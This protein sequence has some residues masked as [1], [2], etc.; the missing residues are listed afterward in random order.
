MA[1]PFIFQFAT[2]PLPLAQLDVNFATPI[3]LGVTPVTLGDTFLTLDGLTSVTSTD[4][5]GNLT[6]NADTVTDGVYTVGDQTIDGTKTFS[7]LIGGSIDG[8]AGTV[9]DG[10]YTTGI[11]FDPAWITALSGEKIIGA[12]N[13]VSI[14]L[15]TP[16]GG[17]FTYAHTSSI[18][19]VQGGSSITVDCALSNVF[20]T[21]LSASITSVTFTNPHDGQT[22]NWFITQDAT[23][24]RTMGW[25]GSF[26]FPG[27]VANGALS[28]AANAVDLVVLTYRANTSF[29]YASVLQDFSSNAPL[30]GGT[31]AA[32]FDTTLTSNDPV[33]IHFGDYSSG[34]VDVSVDWGDG[35]TETVTVNSDV[36]HT[37]DVAGT[38]SV[39]ITGTATGIDLTPI[40]Y[41]YA[42]IGVDSWDSV[43][44]ITQT[45]LN[46]P[47]LTYVPATLPTTITDTGYLFA[48]ATIFNGDISAWDTAAVTNMAGMFQNAAAFNQ[49]IGGWSTSAVTTTYQMFDGAAAF[50]QPIGSWDTS[51]VA[52]MESMF[53]NAALFNQDIS[54]WNTSAVTN[55]R[56]MF[57][58]AVAFDQPIGSWSTSL[59]GTMES[60]F[61]GA[62]AFDQDISGW[63]TQFVTD[64]SNMFAAAASFNQP[65][66]AWNTSAVITMTGMFQSAVAFDQ[67]IGTWVT[68]SVTDMSGMFSGALVFN[69]DIGA[70]DTSACI[71]MTNMFQVAEA[72]NQD[73]SGWTTTLVQNMS[74]MFN[75]AILFNQPIGSWDISAVTTI[76]S[77]FYNAVAFNQPL[78]AWNTSTIT[79]MRNAFSSATSFNQ[80][81]TAWNTAV[82]TDMEGMFNF[83]LVFDQDISTW[84]V[85]LIPSEPTDFNT[86]GVLTPAYFPVWGA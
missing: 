80:P 73:I 24:G 4:F 37:Y 71:G 12:I 62:T 13:G 19:V 23:G 86:G 60:M 44:G 76:E 68:S 27:G 3:T 41:T 43:M 77:M 36:S 85:T 35:N 50:D 18:T 8:N 59:V 49:N 70:W 11:Y 14:G 57:H 7:L 82:V 45:Y 1:V 79:N 21:T 16:A 52:N 31:Y 65:I 61:D 10:V 64:M 38:Y 67:P 46:S 75:G 81:L 17:R 9:T 28:T 83:A 22:I 54:G 47:Y 34:A 78:N 2:A 84:V 39:V 40:G 58:N 53:Q 42:L 51:L 74:A 32:T 15:T 30:P 63:D 25:D 48:G 26:K 55:M 29:W 6:G 5:I 72:F 56:Y 69:Q 33:A 66:G 20:E